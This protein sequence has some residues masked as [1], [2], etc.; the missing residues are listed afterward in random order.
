[1]SEGVLTAAVAALGAVGGAAVT[2]LGAYL[3]QR[4]RRRAQRAQHEDTVRQAL[5]YL[6]LFAIEERG[7]GLLR[8]GWATLEQR[9]SLHRWHALYHDGLGGN[10]DADGLLRAVDKLPLDILE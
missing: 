6:M 5:R 1:M 2:A 9:R 10:G 7:A 8:Q 4:E 3:S